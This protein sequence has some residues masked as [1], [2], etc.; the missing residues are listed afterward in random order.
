[1]HAA[2]CTSILIV[3]WTSAAAAAAAAP[4]VAYMKL[5]KTSHIKIIDFV[6]CSKNKSIYI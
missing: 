6:K 1:M 5:S 3:D 4:N 2:E